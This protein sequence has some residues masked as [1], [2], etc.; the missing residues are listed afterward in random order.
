MSTAESP[1]FNRL[2][3]QNYGK[4][5]ANSLTT[6]E[7]PIFSELSSQLAHSP[8]SILSVSSSSLDSAATFL[9]L[10]GFSVGNSFDR[11]VGVTACGVLGNFLSWFVVNSYECRKVF[12]QGMIALTTI[13]FL[14]GILDVIPTNG[15]RWPNPH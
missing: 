5:R 6:S 10:A 13:L 3:R 9:Q 4:T 14:I 8:A 2:S 7:E 11:G 15:A 12:V 1:L